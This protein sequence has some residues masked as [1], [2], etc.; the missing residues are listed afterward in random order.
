MICNTSERVWSEFNL[1]CC[2]NIKCRTRKRCVCDVNWLR[3]ASGWGGCAHFNCIRFYD[4]PFER[5][6]RNFFPFRFAF[7]FVVHSVESIVSNSVAFIARS[8]VKLWAVDLSGLCVWPALSL[9]YILPFF[10]CKHTSWRTMEETIQQTA[11]T[12]TT[13]NMNKCDFNQSWLC[14]LL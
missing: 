9:H 10:K 11:H 2:S 12:H 13:H 3:C 7:I 4:K 14:W 8:T 6:N 1:I 5:G